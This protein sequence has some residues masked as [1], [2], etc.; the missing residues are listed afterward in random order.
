LPPRIPKRSNAFV[1]CACGGTMSIATVSLFCAHSDFMR[2]ADRC[3]DCG[4]QASFDV[5]KKSK[6]WRGRCVGL[7]PA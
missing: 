1:E 7:A 4:K 6:G 2:H 3:R 5:V